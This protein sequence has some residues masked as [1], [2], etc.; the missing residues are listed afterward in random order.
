[1]LR[2][3]NTKKLAIWQDS[4]TDG[5]RMYL[6]NGSLFLL[7]YNSSRGKNNKEKPDINQ[8]TYIHTNIICLV[9]LDV[10]T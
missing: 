4:I 8:W 9:S 6:E 1:M 5:G 7:I 2:Y 10:K 3:L